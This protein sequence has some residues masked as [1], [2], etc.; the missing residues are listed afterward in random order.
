MLIKRVERER[1]NICNDIYIYV[2]IYSNIKFCQS[3]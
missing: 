2:Y 3:C 1:D